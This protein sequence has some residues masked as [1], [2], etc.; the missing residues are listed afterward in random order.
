MGKANQWI[1]GSHYRFKVSHQRGRQSLDQNIL[2]D[3]LAH[4]VGL[5][6]ESLKDVLSASMREGQPFDR[7][8]MSHV[9]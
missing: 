7:F 6:D 1:A 2:K 5:D 3:Q 9:N 4:A 8:Y